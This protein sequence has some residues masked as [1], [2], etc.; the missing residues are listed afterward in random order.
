MPVLRAM[1]WLEA[2]EDR[3][4]EV[5]ALLSDAEGTRFEAALSASPGRPLGFATREEA[6]TV[7][8]ALGGVCP[9]HDHPVPSPVVTKRSLYDVLATLSWGRIAPLAAQRLLQRLYE[10]DP[11]DLTLD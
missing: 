11:K 9:S 8:R 1:R 6:E 10:T 7:A 3:G 4:F 2:Q 5:H